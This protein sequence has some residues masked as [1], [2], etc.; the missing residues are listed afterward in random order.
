MLTEETIRKI[1]FRECEAMYGVSFTGYRPAKLNF[2]GE[3]DP[4]CV[5][6]KERLAQKILMLAENGADRFFSGM[7]LGV[8]TWCAEA[9]LELKKNRPEITLT[10]VIPCRNQAEGWGPSEQQ[11]YKNLLGGCSKIICISESYTKSCMMQRNRAL[12]E[13]CEVLLAVYDGKK[14]G[15]KY[16]VDYAEKCHKKIIIIPPM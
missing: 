5:D 8:D 16:T 12:V 1:D 6:L 15:T 14:G 7:A 3:D 4:M 2:F 10:A 11:R 9:V 13:M